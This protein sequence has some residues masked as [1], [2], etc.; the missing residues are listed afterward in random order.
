MDHFTGGIEL[1]HQRRK[2]PGVQF[3]VQDVLAVEEK[4]M[5]LGIDAMAAESTR[6]PS[7]WK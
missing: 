3:A 1:D 4:H 6:N 7:I 2:M 5:V